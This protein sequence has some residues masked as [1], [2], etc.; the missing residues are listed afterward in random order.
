MRV[1]HFDL[2]LVSDFRGKKWKVKKGKKERKITP[3]FFFLAASSVRLWLHIVDVAFGTRWWEIL[4]KPS[5]QRGGDG[6]VGCILKKISHWWRKFFFC[7][8][9]MHFGLPAHSSSLLRKGWF[10]P[11]LCCT[12]VSSLCSCHLIMPV[13][14]WR[15]SR[16]RIWQQW[17]KRSILNPGNWVISLVMKSWWAVCFLFSSSSSY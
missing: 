1:F 7:Q 13:E 10:P 16:I 4:A 3:A 9:L 6:C 12:P 2:S 15:E 11:P 8:Q 14:I 17:Q 5:G